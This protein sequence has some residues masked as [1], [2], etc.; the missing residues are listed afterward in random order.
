MKTSANIIMMIAVAALL[1]ACDGAEPPTLRED[2][3]DG[4]S[5]ARLRSPSVK[6]HRELR[7]GT[8]WLWIRRR[9]S[10]R[11]KPREA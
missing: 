7:T 6:S 11:L 8:K 2:P 3:E 5:A 4:P 1:A 9:E 10:V